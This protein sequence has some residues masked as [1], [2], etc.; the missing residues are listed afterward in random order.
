MSVRPA[1]WLKNTLVFAALIFGGRLLDPPS[2]THALVAFVCLCLSAGATYLVNDVWDREADRTHPRKRNR[3]IASGVVSPGLAVGTAAV[4]AA[5][6]VGF[7][8]AVNRPTGLAV[9]GYLALTTVYSFFLKHVVILDVLALAS[10]FVVRVIVGA[11]AIGVEFS[12]WLVLCTFTLALFLG[13]GKRRHELVLLEGNAHSHRPIL[14][15]YSLQ[16]L[17]LMMAV[18]TG[19]AVMSYVL[20]TMDAHTIEH[21]GTRNLIYTSVFVI[22]GIFRALYLIH[23]RRSGGNPADLFYQDRSLLLAVILWVV[24]VALLRYL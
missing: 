21:F 9:L 23:Q 6:G 16:F 14:G 13:F 19:V 12:S 15:E 8:F 3:P 1:E 2:V 18:V 20:Y 22:Y 11:V 4:W 7:A 5:L 24:S 17:D 10:G